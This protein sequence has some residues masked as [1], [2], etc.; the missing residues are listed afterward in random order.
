MT[1][2]DVL[3]RLRDAD[4]I[5]A[6]GLARAV[7]Q[8]R[9]DR[10]RDDILATP[11][12]HDAARSHGGR[13]VRRFAVGLAAAG[14]VAALVVAVGVVTRPAQ[15]GGP[16]VA[17]AAE[18]LHAAGDNA[19]AEHDYVL[20]GSQRVF[21]ASLVDTAG[22][23]QVVL[24][25]EWWTDRKG[26]ATVRT[27]TYTPR[28]ADLFG[29]AVGSNDIE[30][31]SELTNDLGAP[32]WTYASVRAVPTESAAFAGWVA[33]QAKEMKVSDRAPASV[34]S[35]E[36]R[37]RAVVVDVL[38]EPLAPAALRGAAF[39][40]IADLPGVTSLGRGTDAFD[41]PGTLIAIPNRLDSA[42][43]DTLL[44]DPARATLLERRTGE[45][46]ADAGTKGQPGMPTGDATVHATVRTYQGPT[47]V[48][49]D[50]VVP[51]GVNVAPRTS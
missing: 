11:R 49:R 44:I 33:R 21:S 41:R 30:R 19:R 17:S 46:Q 6:G 50:L 7:P 47:V 38:T 20:T 16:A 40:L 24:S 37:T 3:A 35:I 43:R 34:S 22:P 4:P 29:V 8:P 2:T 25:G 28:A 1:T 51:A 36:A 9:R 10:L 5:T 27:R 31:L 39:D 23:E 12:G 48:T 18:I 15:V 32:R 14:T 45:A 42:V 26:H 13:T